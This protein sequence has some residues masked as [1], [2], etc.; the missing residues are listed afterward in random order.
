VEVAMA[1]AERTKED[2]KQ[3]VPKRGKRASEVTNTEDADLRDALMK[4]QIG[5]RLFKDFFASEPMQLV[6]IIRS[7]VPATATTALAGTLGLSQDQ[8]FKDLGFARA[9]VVRKVSKNENLSSEQSERVVGLMK[10][11]GQVATM[12]AESGEP[13][14]F[15][16][17]RW[18]GEWI[19]KPN[20]ALGA[21]RPA[22]LM[23]TVQGQKIVSDLLLK[24]QTGAYA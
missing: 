2:P 8:L 21:V 3:A 22:E 9:T 11:I 1:V 23:D 12:I 15:D 17:A 7:G 4:R 5:T 18:V 6:T 10:L 24:M 20:P 13:T 14:G 19:H 16:A